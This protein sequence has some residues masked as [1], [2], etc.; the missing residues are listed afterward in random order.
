M[1]CAAVTPETPPGDRGG[2]AP[3]T[4]RIDSTR[5]CEMRGRG[6]FEPVRLGRRMFS[7]GAANDSDASRAGGPSNCEHLGDPTP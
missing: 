2:A 4:D 3:G 1:P 6:L 5:P 7:S